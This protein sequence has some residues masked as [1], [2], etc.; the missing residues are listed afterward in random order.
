MRITARQQAIR[1]SYSKS[2]RLSACLS[3]AGIVS[4]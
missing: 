1:T 2:V 4:K 3:R